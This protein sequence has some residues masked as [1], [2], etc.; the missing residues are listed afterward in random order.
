M[1]GSGADFDR[2]VE[3]SPHEPR[4]IRRYISCRNRNPKTAAYRGSSTGRTLVAPAL[5]ADG[6]A[7]T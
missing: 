1:L 5:A 7:I 6:P 2:V 4:A 3:G